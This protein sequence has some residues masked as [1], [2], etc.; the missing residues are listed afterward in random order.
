[1]ITIVNNNSF[2]VEITVPLITDL[3]C[4]DIPACPIKSGES[5]LSPNDYTSRIIKYGEDCDCIV[6]VKTEAEEYSIH[7]N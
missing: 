1:M 7:I 5:I 3:K 6:T 4:L 2:N